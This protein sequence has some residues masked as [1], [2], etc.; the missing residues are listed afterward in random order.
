MHRI[1]FIQN[2]ITVIVGLVYL[3]VA[4]SACKKFVT[5]DP[6]VTQLVTATVFNNNTTATA[7]L[8]SLYTSANGYGYTIALNTGLS[9]DELVNYSTNT[10]QVMCYT[11]SLNASN[12]PS[13]NIWIN[14]Y[15][16]IYGANA[17]LEGLA[18]GNVSPVVTKQLTGEAKFLRAFWYFYLTN[19]FGDVPLITSTN[20]QANAHAPRISQA[21]VYQQ[22]IADL[23]DAMNVLNANYVDATDTLISAE[24]VRPN[25]STATALLAR[26]YLYTGDFANAEIQASA[27]IDNT[28]LY[29]LVNNLDSIFLKNNREAIWQLMALANGYN[30]QEG[31]LFILTTTP[32]SQAIS[33]QLLNA[34][35]NN[36][37]R[38]SKWIGVFASGANKY[39]YPYKYKI[40]SGTVLTEYTTVLRLSELYL[41][42]A[43][44]RAQQNKLDAALNDL[45]M[46]RSRAG[47]PNAVA[48]T[49]SELLS[50]ILHERQVELFTE[51]GHR[52][53]DLKRTSSVDSVMTRITP[54]KGGTWNINAQWYPLPQTELQNNPNLKQNAGY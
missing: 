21:L 36:D 30:T 47:L 41:I 43:E 19:L 50:A 38:R 2:K 34:F 3:L 10:S 51:W 33:N 1:F 17:I 24:R 11:N 7:A 44:A 15:N 39:Y 46:I 31:Y 48:S 6:P 37:K 4:C 45:N 32:N 5:V 27:V 14:A 9:S 13:N 8:T 20:Y 42:R 29:G 23:K 25:K 16:Y 40:Q 28:A 54:L 12:S 53:L 35:E 49:K 18:T 22:I 26:V 52:W